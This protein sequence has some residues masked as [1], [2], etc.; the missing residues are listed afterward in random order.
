GEAVVA[1][2]WLALPVREEQAARLRLLELTPD[3]LRRAALVP[4]PDHTTPFNIALTARGLLVASGRRVS[5]L[6][7][8]R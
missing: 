8:E 2:R 6:A 4:L 5:L 1:G 3:G 7:W